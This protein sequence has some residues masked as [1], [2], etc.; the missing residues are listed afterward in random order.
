MFPPMKIPLYLSG[1][2]GELRGSHFHSGLDF[3]TQ[4]RIGIPVYAMDDGYV[5]RVMVSPWGF[6]RAVYIAHASGYTT[7]YG[8][9]DR[10][11]PFIDKIVKPIQYKN[12]NFSLTQYFKPGEIP[13]QKG[14]IIAYSGNAGSSGG[15]HLHLDIRET[16]TEKPVDPMPFFK[17][18]IRDA[19]APDPR[20]VV[21]YPIN[22]VVDGTTEK[23]R[24][25]VIKNESGNYTLARPFR[26]WGDPALGIK[27]YDR[28]DGTTNIY[29]VKKTELYVDGIL[30]FSYCIDAFSFDESRYL[31]SFIDYEDKILY[32]SIVMKSYVDPGNKL[33]GV[34]NDVVNRGVFRIN[35]E[36]D[37]NCRYVLSDGF[38]NRSVVNFTIQGIKQPVPV[39]KE[40]GHRMK[41]NQANLF[42]EKGV[43]LE[44][45]PD[46]FYDDFNFRYAA[47]KEPGYVSDVH[48]LHNNT[49]PMHRFA[50]LTIKLSQDNQRD[51][52]TYYMVHINGKTKSTVK[53][54]YQ[55]GYLIS[56]IRDLGTYA[57]AIDTVKPVITPI[58]P[59]QWGRTGIVTLRISDRHSGVENYKGTIDGKFV[60]FELD[61]K[62]ARASYKL[63]PS[64]VSGGRMHRLRFTV[65][66]ACGNEQVYTRDF[67]W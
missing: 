26:A 65:T 36:R 52:Q 21:L 17:T 34:Y 39:K 56:K 22:G 7:V 25:P 61:G 53:G 15:P 3:K 12:E 40:V 47:R 28:M 42:V 11:A 13:V 45:P 67:K 8:H 44:I 32:K 20:Q 27:A 37:Y 51:K 50:T 38:G 55:N 23:C 6:G 66:D 63:E 60:L 29:G 9:L 59:E 57:V 58:K 54:R 62:T 64:R 14:R 4:G 19:V 1:N 49:V 30:L 41:Y 10:F 18:L 5:S 31:N 2:F 16:R 24:Q 43:R 46:V 35:E 33:S 48:V